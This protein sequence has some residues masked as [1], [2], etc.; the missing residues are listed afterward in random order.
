MSSSKRAQLLQ[1]KSL[2]VFST[3]STYF[4]K[5]RHRTCARNLLSDSEFRDR[6]SF[7]EGRKWIS[8]CTFHKYSSILGKFYVR[9]LYLNFSLAVLSSSL[10]SCHITCY[11]LCKCPVLQII[12]N[13]STISTTSLL[14]QEQSQYVSHRNKFI[15]KQ[16]LYSPG[17][18]L[19]VPEGWGSQ[20]SRQLAHEGGK[21]VSPTHRPTL[22]PRKYSWYSLLLE[23]QSIPGP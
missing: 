3:F 2:S 6:L 1:K 10:Q 20:I 17:Q 11:I 19:M 23:A 12:T 18:A 15:V 13:I 21:D 7:T 9:H 8:F 14:P 5:R 4:T 22:P 16:S